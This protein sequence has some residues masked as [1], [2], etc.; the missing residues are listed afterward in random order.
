MF[1]RAVADCE[2]GPAREN[3][4]VVSVDSG[5]QQDLAERIEEQRRTLGCESGGGDGG[6]I[7][8]QDAAGNEDFDELAAGGLAGLDVPGFGNFVQCVFCG[9]ES[10]LEVG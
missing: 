6:V 8:V 3:V 10:V 9:E 1:Y 2:I 7:E 4:V 5:F